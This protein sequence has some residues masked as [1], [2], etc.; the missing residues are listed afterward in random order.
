MLEKVRQKTMD[1]NL[2]QYSAVIL[3]AGAGTRMSSL[4]TMP[5]CLLPISGRSL[6]LHQLNHAAELG[7]SEKIVVVGYQHDI[8]RQHLADADCLEDV[9]LVTSHDYKTKGNGYSL[10]LGAQHVS[11]AMVVFDG[12]LIYD[13]PILTKFLNQG[14]RNQVLVGP[15]S[16][17]DLECA[18][19]LVDPAGN[20]NSVIDK[21][22][23]IETETARFLGE[24][25]GIL[26]FSK[27]GRQKLLKCAEQF[28]GN[29][30]NLPLNWEHLI[31]QYV[32]DNPMAAWYDQSDK[33]VEIDTP[34][35]YD[36][37]KHKFENMTDNRAGA[38]S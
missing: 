26:M 7:F 18:K 13:R 30:G 37:A 19:A 11:H 27:Q 15:G 33:W 38:F 25:I 16:I 29:P 35:D 36:V 23:A 24:A 3:V 21:S 32:V 12:D 9:V 28:F 17:D 8:I 31:N 20:I 6:L 34:E 14:T 1:T 5:K 2:P 10:Y 4:T 22:A